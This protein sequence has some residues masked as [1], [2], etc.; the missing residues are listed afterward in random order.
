MRRLIA[1]VYIQRDTVKGRRLYEAPMQE[2][3]LWAIAHDKKLKE[4]QG[5]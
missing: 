2:R 4:L 5:S 3:T 1:A